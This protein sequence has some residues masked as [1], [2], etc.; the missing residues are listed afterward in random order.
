MSNINRLSFFA[1]ALVL[2]FGVV[3]SIQSVFG[4]LSASAQTNDANDINDASV[5]VNMGVKTDSSVRPTFWKNFTNRWF[6]NNTVNNVNNFAPA[7]DNVSI[8]TTNDALS[9]PKTQSVKYDYGMTNGPTENT[10]GPFAGTKETQTGIFGRWNLD[11]VELNTPNNNVEKIAVGNMVLSLSNTGK[12]ELVGTCNYISGTWQLGKTTTDERT[13]QISFSNVTATEKPCV[14]CQSTECTEAKAR[15]DKYLGF[16]KS[17]QTI[18]G[19]NWTS[20]RVLNLIALDDSKQKVFFSFSR[21]ASV[22]PI[23]GGVKPIK[24]IRPTP[25]ITKVPEKD[26]IKQPIT[27]FSDTAIG[28]RF[29]QTFRQLTETH[30]K[31]SGLADRVEAQA[32]KMAANGTNI[33]AETNYILQAQANLKRV[34]TAIADAQTAFKLELQTYRDIKP[35][36]FGGSSAINSSI[37]SSENSKKYFAKTIANINTAKASLITAKGNIDQAW[38]LLKAKLQEEQEARGGDTDNTQNTNQSVDSSL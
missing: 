31:L 6:K 22:A 15:T 36:S 7:P 12:F 27:D 4:V 16:F 35:E 11:S 14:I 2:V 5:N 17:A 1:I 10:T 30:K 34:S 33:T 29:D 18:L 28:S 3:F 9:Y 37:N 8:P 26:P 32:K 19:N 20:P 25:P 23:D 21:G 38:S 13:G 24:P